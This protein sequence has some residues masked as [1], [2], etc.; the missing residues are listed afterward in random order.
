MPLFSSIERLLRS[1]RTPLALSLVVALCYLSFLWRHALNIPQGDDITDVLMVMTRA[2]QSESVAAFW[3]LLW[4]QHNDH[5]TLASRLVYWL[6]LQ[7]QGEMNFRT[8]A[9]L[10]NGLL[11]GLLA[12]F[13]A[14]LA[15]P[16]N[17]NW[18]L[19][20]AALILLQWRAYDLVLWSMAGFAYFGAFFYGCGSL[21]LLRSANWQRLLLAMLLAALSTCSLASGQ[22]V[23][24]VGFLSLAQQWIGGRR[25][26]RYFLAAWLV[27]A[28]L[29]LSFWHAGLESPNSLSQLLALFLER[30]AHLSHYF[31]VLCGAAVGE[32]SVPM[33]TALGLGLLLIV[34]L[35]LPMS[36]RRDELTLHWM[37]L[38]ALG[39]IAAVT[40]GRGPA[41]T[42]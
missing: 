36:W 7:L 8:L 24:L 26:A 10:A 22:L 6:T 27:A 3:E 38:F 1:S 2:A 30:P 40:L 21:L 17:R 31:L 39:S 34:G 18:L 20:G 9:F 35:T 41:A 37:A 11:L 29:F 13:A 33:A 25:E 42:N 19:L 12:L 16:A 32:Q 4:A 15:K 23:W 5:R 14:A 28:A